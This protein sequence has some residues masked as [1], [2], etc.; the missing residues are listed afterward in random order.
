MTRYFSRC[1]VIYSQIHDP[2][3]F[4]WHH[5][6]WSSTSPSPYSTRQRYEVNIGIFM[7]SKRPHHSLR[8][9]IYQWWQSTQM[10][11]SA[12][13]VSKVEELFFYLYLMKTPYV[14]Y[15]LSIQGRKKNY[16]RQHELNMTWRGGHCAMAVNWYRNNLSVSKYPKKNVTSVIFIDGSYVLF[17]FFFMCPEYTE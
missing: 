7:I 17:L 12:H 4:L 6:R 8:Y 5:H 16:H 15:G 13:T 14:M 1:F 10:L 3:Q 2:N 11:M 9:N